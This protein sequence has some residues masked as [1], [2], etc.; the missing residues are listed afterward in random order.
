MNAKDELELLA[1]AR[2]IAKASESGDTEVLQELISDKYSI[3]GSGSLWGTHGKFGNKSGALAV[4]NSKNSD[5]TPDV[6]VMS[7][8]KVLIL[9]NTGVVTYL[10]TDAW[11][12]E[13]GEHE[14]LAWVTDTWVRQNGKWYLLASHE[15]IFSER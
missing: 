4:W 14:I 15:S 6:S 9:D 7:D 2:R 10:M 5:G 12:D 1:S 3:T 11:V 13:S 8:E